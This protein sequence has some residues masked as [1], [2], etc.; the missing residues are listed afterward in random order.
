MSRKTNFDNKVITIGC[1]LNQS[2][3]DALRSLNF[4][5]GQNAV[6]IN[7]CAVTQSAVRTSW[8]TIRRNISTK[9]A[10]SKLI[11][12]GCLATL[13]KSKLLECTG[14]DKVLT[15]TEKTA[16]LE[17]SPPVTD[18]SQLCLNRSRPLVKIQDGCPNHCS[19]CIACL[20][21]GKAKSIPVHTIL[22]HI[23]NLVTRGYQEIVLTGLNLGSYGIDT[24]TSLT[25]LLKNI[26]TDSCRIRLSSIQPDTIT[27]ELLGLWQ[28]KNLCRHLHIP[29]Q[30]GDDRIL[31]LMRRKYTV[32]NYCRLIQ[33]LH[34]KIPGINIGTD[35][36][37]GFPTE[38]EQ[39]FNKTVK[40]A[41]QLPFG[42]LHVFPYSA[43]VGTEAAK[44][45]DDVSAKIKK[46]RVQ[47]LRKIAEQK[48]TDFRHK[49]INTVLP[50]I[51]EKKNRGLSD[52]YLS[53]QLPRDK[54][55][56]GKLYNIVLKE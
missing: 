38:D 39:S 17:N 50:V 18:N 3:S 44:F 46:E 30:S 21:R 13:E 14:I 9:H 45:K 19:F 56:K 5:N 15:Q 4:L 8:K 35:I 37:V 6:I 23:N 42:Y 51:A 1:R 22:K 32:A 26:D 54:Y 25:E 16:L 29:L 7:T 43:R 27:D 20:V 52:N 49:F 31:Q 12:T 28:T 48:K 53:L 36:I 24:N 2:E 33:K 47:I 10:R 34:A 41:E 40:I 55:E 11:I